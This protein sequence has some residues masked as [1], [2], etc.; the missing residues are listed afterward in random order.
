MLNNTVYTNPKT[1][2]DQN[3]KLHH[4]CL[5]FFFFFSVFEEEKGRIQGLQTKFECA[6]TERSLTR[7]RSDINQ[8]SRRALYKIQRLTVVNYDMK[9]IFKKRFVLAT[10]LFIR[11]T[12]LQF[13]RDRD[14]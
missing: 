10:V 5:S 6:C 9:V 1:N 12:A 13:K 3:S 2:C 14:G 11:V 7:K 4:V 8:S